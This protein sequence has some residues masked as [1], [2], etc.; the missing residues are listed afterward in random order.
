MPTY[1]ANPN[2]E[3][4]RPLYKDLTPYAFSMYLNSVII[5]AP[6]LS[7]FMLAYPLNKSKGYVT[8]IATIP[9]IHPL[10]SSLGLLTLSLSCRRYFLQTSKL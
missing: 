3:I 2:K 10:N 4:D 9:A 5:F 6:D 1:G 8:I 7:V